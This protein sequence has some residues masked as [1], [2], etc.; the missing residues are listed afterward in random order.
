M[1]KEYMKPQIEIIS[2]QGTESITSEDDYYQSVVP[3][4]FPIDLEDEEQ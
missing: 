2:L 1:K 4:P 3:N